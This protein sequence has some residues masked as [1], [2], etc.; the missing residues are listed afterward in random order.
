LI[1]GNNAIAIIMWRNS[2][3]FHSMDK[4]VRCVQLVS[5]SIIC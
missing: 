3:V 1:M 2:L 4:V 5:S